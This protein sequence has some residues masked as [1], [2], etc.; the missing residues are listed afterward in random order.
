MKAW[1]Q[2]K[3][4]ANAGSENSYEQRQQN[5]S[6]TKQQQQYSDNKKARKQYSD[7]KTSDHPPTGG[8]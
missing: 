8:E 6:E 7:R 4:T 2:K 5:D 1:K 3:K